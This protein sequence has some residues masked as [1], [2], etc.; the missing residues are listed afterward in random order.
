MPAAP[1]A[2][3]SN[4]NS[5]GHG[6]LGKG[7]CFCT[8]KHRVPLWVAC[9][10]CE[11]SVDSYTPGSCR[12]P[13]HSSPKSGLNSQLGRIWP[14][15]QLEVA[16]LL[17]R[18]G[19]GGAVLHHHIAAHAQLGIGPHHS[20]LVGHLRHHPT[21]SGAGAVTAL[22]ATHCRSE[23]SNRGPEPHRARRPPMQGHPTAGPAR[24]TACQQ[25][26][27]AE[28]AVLLHTES[29]FFGAT[30]ATCTMSSPRHCQHSHAMATPLVLPSWAHHV[31]ASG[32]H[33][34]DSHSTY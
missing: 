8:C 1:Q 27:H 19:E 21:H 24:V 30:Q 26:C 7:L 17:A 2:T 29:A 14:C 3:L 9:A 13:W 11:N 6:P 32:A 25:P 15:L 5:T 16:E 22:S 33:Q 23:F 20:G 12:P 28:R 31:P 18:S 10:A 34:S 4:F